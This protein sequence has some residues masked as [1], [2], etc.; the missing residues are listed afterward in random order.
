MIKLG[1][2]T[3]H[4]YTR[5]D[6]KVYIYMID[7]CSKLLCAEWFKYILNIFLKYTK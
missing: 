5:E 1:K 2:V 3:C 7:S 4:S 6:Y